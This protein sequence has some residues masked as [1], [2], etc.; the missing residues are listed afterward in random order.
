M[1]SSRGIPEEDDGLILA[2]RPVSIHRSA[3]DTLLPEDVDVGV[4]AS[5]AATYRLIQ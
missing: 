4:G 3:F 1:D 2:G 5:S